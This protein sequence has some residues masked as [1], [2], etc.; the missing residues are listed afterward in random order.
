[1]TN[2]EGVTVEEPCSFHRQQNILERSHLM[3]WLLIV[4]ILQF[5]IKS[6]I[7]SRAWVFTERQTDTGTERQRQIE[8]PL[9]NI[10]TVKK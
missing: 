7:L 4:L 10:L 3:S 5:S 1:M 2:G 8:K 9:V 6:F